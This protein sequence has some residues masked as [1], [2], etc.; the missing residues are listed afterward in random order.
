MRSDYHAL[1]AQSEL[2]GRYDQWFGE[3]LN[4]ARIASVVTYHDL[5]PGFQAVLD[6]NG[7]NLKAFFAEVETLADQPKPMRR[8]VLARISHRPP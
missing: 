4:N 2:E 3:G 5:L 1:R 8:K 7:G 6:R